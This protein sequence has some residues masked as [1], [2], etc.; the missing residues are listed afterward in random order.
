MITGTVHLSSCRVYRPP[1]YQTLSVSDT[2]IIGHFHWITFI[3]I[4]FI[5]VTLFT[6]HL[7]TADV[8]PNNL[9]VTN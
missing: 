7:K 5:G 1:L 4:I 3:W 9:V 2:I 8:V 6:S